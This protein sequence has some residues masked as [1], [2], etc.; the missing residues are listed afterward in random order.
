MP[1]TANLEGSTTK[2]TTKIVDVNQQYFDKEVT[3]KNKSVLIV[4]D[5]GAPSKGATENVLHMGKVSTEK[6]QWQKYH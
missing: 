3:Q 2:L 5:S 6:T 4:L 1:R